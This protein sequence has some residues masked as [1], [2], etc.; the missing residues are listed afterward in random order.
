MFGN[1]KETGHNPEA[2]QNPSSFQL[3]STN[4]PPAYGN[5]VEQTR[6]GL[7]NTNVPSG[8]FTV[9]STTQSFAGLFSTKNSTAST[10]DLK[11]LVVKYVVKKTLI[12]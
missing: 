1:K 8:L 9:P 12:E 4:L 7:S 5:I 10:G 2:V 6:E 3:S 11:H